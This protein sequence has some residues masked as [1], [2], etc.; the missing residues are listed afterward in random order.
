MV[1]KRA[2]CDCIVARLEAELALQTEA[3]HSSRAEATDEETRAEGKYDMRGQSAAYLAQ[4]QAKLASEIA[5]AIAAY[6]ALP[7]RLLGAG[8][9]IAAGALATLESGGARTVYFIG[10]AR[11]GMEV[12]ISG[13]P[14]VVITAASTLGRSLLGKRVGDR[15]APPSRTQAAA[16]VV[17]AVE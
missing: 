8:E 12:E 16:S 9:S 13:V 2:L 11:G 3:A 7:I 5:G 1:D 6:R 17:V 4:G 14:V 10:P 15:I